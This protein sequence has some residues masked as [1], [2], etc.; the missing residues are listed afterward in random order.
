MKL[1]TFSRKKVLLGILFI[2]FVWFGYLTLGL[3]TILPFGDEIPDQ[4]DPKGDGIN[5]LDVL[6]PDKISEAGALPEILVDNPKDITFGGNQ[7]GVQDD[8]FV[9][10]RIEREKMRSQQV[11]ILRE[12]VDNPNSASEVRKNAQEKMLKL[13]ENIENELKL[14]N[15]IKA[16]NYED[17]VVLIQPESVMVV[18]K[19]MALT[20]GDGTKI[21]DLVA[22]TTGYNYENIIITTK[23]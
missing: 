6:E 10:Y 2:C 11:E 3:G 22:N 7:S 4:I 17:A 5:E 23:E 14:E 12:I 1:V 18:V 21:A 13:T 19:V 16:K 15:L 9:N 20:D 8:Y